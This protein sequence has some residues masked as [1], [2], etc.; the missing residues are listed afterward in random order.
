[1]P[2]CEGPARRRRTLDRA[3]AHRALESCVTAAAVDRNA[4]VAH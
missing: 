1:M 4:C 3:A 2:R